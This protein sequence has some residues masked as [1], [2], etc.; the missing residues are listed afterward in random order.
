MAHR[1]LD[2]YLNDHLGGATAG[3]D[4]AAQIRD[5]HE[6]EELGAVMRSLAEEIEADRK[7]LLDL[8]ERV[9]TEPSP[10]KQ[11]TGWLFEKVSRVKF[12]GVLSG[13]PEHG[14]FMALESLY[15][16]V[17]GKAS[18]WRSLKEVAD[19]YP[20]LATT[21]LDKLV[22]RAEEQKSILD[23]EMAATAR[24]V[25]TKNPDPEHVNAY[26]ADRPPADHVLN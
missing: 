14:T 13:S 2:T 16:G 26:S 11:A 24:E 3:S 18:M 1:A 9:G 15:L 5:R 17:E 4:L 10:I 23:R 25:L 12:S 20:A 6:G 22:G 19:E 8:M 21:D 7:T